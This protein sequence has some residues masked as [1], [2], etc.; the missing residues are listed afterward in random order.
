M[1][2]P[3]TNFNSSSSSF[4]FSRKVKQ[5]LSALFDLVFLTLS[6]WAA[7]ALRFTEWWPEDWL[8]DGSL[9]FVLS[10]LMGVTVFYFL[11]LYRIIIRYVN[12]Q[13]ATSIIKGLF[14][15]SIA[16]YILIEILNLTVP[17]SIP[18]IF[19]LNSFLLIFGYRLLIHNYY[20]WRIKKVKTSRVIIYGAGSAGS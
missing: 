13:M 20:Q 18:V 1:D 15:V 6:L 11:D 17:R 2:N 10:P 19:S 5:L 12:L 3:S 14:L 8:S 9:L 4:Q 7:Y 16:V